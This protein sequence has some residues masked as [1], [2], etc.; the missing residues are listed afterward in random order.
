MASNME[1]FRTFLAEMEDDIQQNVVDGV[2][3]VLKENSIKVCGRGCFLFVLALLSVYF[4]FRA[5]PPF[6]SCSDNGAL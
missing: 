1:D 4:A 6:A 2:I 3:E 5:F